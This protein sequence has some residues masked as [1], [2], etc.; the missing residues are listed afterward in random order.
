MMSLASTI[1]PM[2]ATNRL[3][4]RQLFNWQIVTLDGQAIEL[5][6]GLEIQPHGCLADLDGGDLLILVAGFETAVLSTRQTESTLRKLRSKYTMI[7]GVEAGSW[8][9]GRAGLL[10]GLSATTH[11]E[12]LE[13][14]TQ[15]FR[16]VDVRPD[17][18]VIDKNII[19]TGGASPTFDFMLHLIRQRYGY[20]L[21]QEVASIFIYDQARGRDEAQPQISLGRLNDISPKVAESIRIMEAQI[22]APLTVPAI[23]KRV[24]LP[25]RT[26]E[27]Q[28][29][30]AIGASP[31]MY[32]LRLRLQFAR[33]LLQ[34][35]ALPV[36]E[37][38]VRTGFGAAA[39]FSTTFKKKY[40]H[41][42]QA[43]RNAR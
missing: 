18:F 29:K 38:A 13:E 7:A 34:N 26:Y 42:P 27:H 4:N 20:P 8:V 32:F 30:K 15:K 40:G 14:F 35:T 1:D 25:V 9:L 5:T 17:R 31:G 6:C 24:G 39:S 37:I 3:A 33:K 10:A 23:A 19:T 21:A 36:F 43:Y 2:R 22:D 16:D 12:D 41:S 11:W 28:F